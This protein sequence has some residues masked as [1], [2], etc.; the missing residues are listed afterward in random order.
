MS[1]ISHQPLIQVVTLQAHLFDSYRETELLGTGHIMEDVH[2]VV[3]S[4]GF[5]ASRT[6]HLQQHNTVLAY[7]FMFTAALRLGTQPIL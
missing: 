3:Q 4:E 6:H 7:L 5:G 2:D 1:E